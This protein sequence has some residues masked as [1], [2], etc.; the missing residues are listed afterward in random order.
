[1]ATALI[2]KLKYAIPKVKLILCSVS[3]MTPVVLAFIVLTFPLL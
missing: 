3:I 1:M 2:M